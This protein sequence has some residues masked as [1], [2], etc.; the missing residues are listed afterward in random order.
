MTS[1]SLVRTVGRPRKNSGEGAIDR[2]QSQTVQKALAIL[3]AVA[4]AEEG[5]KLTDV[6][7]SL[8]LSTS[9]TH[10]LLATLSQERFV[11]RDPIS[12]RYELGV[13]FIELARL[14]QRQHPISLSTL[15]LMQKLSRETDDVI[16]LMLEDHGEALCVDRVDGKAPVIIAGSQIGARLPLHCGGAPF[17]L[18]AFSSNQYIDDYLRTP[19]SKKTPKTVV[20]P[21]AVRKR[22]EEARRRG[23]TVGDEDLFEHVVAVGAPVFG[24]GGRMLGSLSIG[25]IKPRFDRARIKQVGEILRHATD[26][27]S[28]NLAENTEVMGEMP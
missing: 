14:S 17:A 13:R 18:L 28:R 9:V 21:N 8:G 27:L 23:Y 24:L 12:G 25:G 16:L 6:S 1:G 4:K 2:S 5:F 26:F 19:L 11:E 22:I 10:R 7:R 20:E 3:E 15:N